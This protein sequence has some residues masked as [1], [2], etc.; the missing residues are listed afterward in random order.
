MAEA[1]DSRPPVWTGHVVLHSADPIAA[2]HFYEQIGMRPVQLDEQF[3]VL[4]MRGGTHLAIR[5]DPEHAAPGPAVWDLMVDDLDAIHDKW[6]AHGFP[7]SPIKD[8]P[9][10]RCFELTDPDGHV[11]TVRDS[12]VIGP[13]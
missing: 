2:A 3:S 13:V 8:G 10:H 5:H 4:E 6:Q 7:V 12:H 1:P 9:P 11:L